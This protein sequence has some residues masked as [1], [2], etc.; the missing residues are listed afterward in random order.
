[1][2]NLIY[3][4]QSVVP[5]FVLI[6]MDDPDKVN[7]FLQISGEFLNETENNSDFSQSG[8]CFL[9]LGM[10]HGIMAGNDDQLPM[11]GEQRT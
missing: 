8:I 11:K 9:I 2:E 1:M 4:L 7:H 5:L 10:G 3:S 6:L